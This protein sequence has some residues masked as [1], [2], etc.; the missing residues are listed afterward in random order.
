MSGMSATARPAGRRAFTL[1]E[2]LVVIAIIGVL[3]GLL[4]PA[5][6]AAREAARR[7]ECTNNLKQIGIAI[8]N[9][10][11]QLGTYPSGY[12]IDAAAHSGDSR[13]SHNVESWGWAVLL[14]PFIEMGPLHDKLKPKERELMVLI[15]DFPQDH[16]LLQTYIP[17]YACPTDPVQGTLEYRWRHFNGRGMSSKFE[18]GQM[19]YV[20]NMGLYDRPWQGGWP[21][22]NNGSFF[23]NSEIRSTE[24][25]DGTSHTFAIGE[26]DSRCYAAS[27]PGVRNPPGPC[28]WGIYH[29]LGRVSFKLNSPEDPQ[30]HK[31][32]GTWNSGG[33]CNNCSEA[34]SSM[35]SGGANFLMCDGSVHFVSEYI[36]FSN[37]GLSYNQLRHGKA[38]TKPGRL[39]LYQR[40]GIRDDEQEVS[41]LD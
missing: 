19:N 28:N 16:A 6:Q 31:D 2:L 21:Y 41:G 22:M 38:V 26:R 40:L 3:I 8:Q 30:W 24:I 12:V 29:T 7:A 13:K 39:G 4:L 32:R 20:A 18:V 5:V 36:E 11:A 37:A 25:Y 34:F 9:Y 35:H 10:E 23:G 33:S 27:W 1:V 17:E 15:R 14:M